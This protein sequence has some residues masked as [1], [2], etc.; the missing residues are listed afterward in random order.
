MYINR[1][2]AIEQKN[3]GMKQFYKLLMNSLYGKFGQKQYNRTYYTKPEF[4]A[5]YLLNKE[6]KIIL[7]ELELDYIKIQYKETDDMN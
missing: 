3:Q 2:K 6:K 5:E 7:T 1:K 4:L